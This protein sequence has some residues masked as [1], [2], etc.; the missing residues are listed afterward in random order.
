MEIQFDTAADSITIIRLS[1]RMDIAGTDAIEEQLTAH[2]MKVDFGRIL[3]DLS[4]VSYLASIGLGCIVRTAQAVDRLKGKVVLLNPQPIVAKVLAESGVNQRIRVF[5][6]MEAAT[7][8]LSRL[9]QG[10]E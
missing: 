5:P 9:P 8:F 6:A 4:N 2:A 3:I 10:D 1:G 7:A